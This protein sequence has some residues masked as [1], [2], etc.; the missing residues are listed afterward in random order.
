MRVGIL[1][2]PK[3]ARTLHAYDRL[4][5]A[6]R[7]ER[8][9]YRSATTTQWWPG[10]QQARQL[11]DWNSE[12]I[13]VLGGDGTLRAAAPLLSTATAPVALI[14]T[15][16]ANVLA[17][18]AGIR[19]IDYALDMVETHLASHSIPALTIPVNEADCLSDEGTRHEHFLSL[20]G[21]GGDALAVAGRMGLPGVFG[22]VG[23][24]VRALFATQMM[25]RIDSDHMRPVW[26]VMASKTGRP[27][28]P[29]TV[30]HHAEV[31]AQNFE[32]LAV[33]LG[34][35]MPDARPQPHV[36]TGGPASGGDSPGGRL[37][38]GA[39][40]IEGGS[41]HDRGS[42]HQR[43]SLHQWARICDW[44]R[45]ARD[46]LQG[47]LAKNPAMQYWTGSGL[48]VRVDAPAPVQLDGDLIGD[49]RGLDIRAGT[50]ALRL[51]APNEGNG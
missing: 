29:I 49:C 22:Y 37:G 34:V 36:G 47:R 24:A 9:A 44:A 17:R 5:G 40:H 50:R 51:L 11:L 1:V 25:A 2:N 3:H 30:F 33:G 23:G 15:G 35:R 41:L 16:T 42:L 19:S 8:I 26:S 12:L 6:L 43:E 20:A 28:G 21:I 46:G 38:E 4:V 10:A 32:L 13:V 45:I 18:H 48:S 27:A 39:S 7:R 31:S 14:P